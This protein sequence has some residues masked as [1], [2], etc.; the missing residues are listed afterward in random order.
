MYPNLAPT[1]ASYPQTVYYKLI[2]SGIAMI[3]QRDKR[4]G[5]VGESDG[6]WWAIVGKQIQ[7]LLLISWATERIPAWLFILFAECIG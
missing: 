4:V 5:V 1:G 7:E 3:A 2:S 6:D